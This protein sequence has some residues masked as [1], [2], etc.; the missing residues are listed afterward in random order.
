MAAIT[1][2]KELVTAIQTGIINPVIS[3]LFALATALFIWGVVMYV[4][5]SK[6]DQ[7]KL[8]RGKNV[9]IWGIVGMFIMVSAWGIIRILCQFFGTCN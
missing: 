7:R 4:I 1:T 8:E 9:M 5:G 2:V 3:L 6:G